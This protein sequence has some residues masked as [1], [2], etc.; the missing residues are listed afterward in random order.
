MSQKQTIF[1]G[2]CINPLALHQALE[3][4]TSL[5]GSQLIAIKVGASIYLPA[6]VSISQR[7]HKGT[8]SV[9]VGDIA[10]TVSQRGKLIKVIKLLT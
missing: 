4:L 9:R 6:L 7:T 1:S 10:F 3:P 5:T 2:Q 8:L